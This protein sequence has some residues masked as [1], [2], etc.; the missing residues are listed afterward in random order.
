MT[1]PRGSSYQWRVSAMSLFRGSGGW[2]LAAGAAFGALAAAGGLAAPAATQARATPIR[3]VVVIFQENQ[4][5]D[6][7][8]GYWCDGH[9]GRCPGGGMPPSVRLSN[10]VVVTPSTSP[11]TVPNVNH[12]VAAQVAAIDDGKMDGWQNI[13]GGTCDAA[14]GYRCVS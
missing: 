7:L 2:V 6:S 11:D 3:H 9:P 5:F 14:T 1:S 8:L 10:G 13:P 12:S 4:S